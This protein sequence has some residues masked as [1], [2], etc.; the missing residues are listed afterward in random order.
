MHAGGR[1]QLQLKGGRGGGVKSVRANSAF[2][3]SGVGISVGGTFDLP[4]R[5]SRGLN[6]GPV[7]VGQEVTTVNSIVSQPSKCLKFM[8]FREKC[9]V[10]RN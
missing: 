3:P 10:I 7:T 6:L 8:T 2:H 4:G 5:N 9:F 1:F